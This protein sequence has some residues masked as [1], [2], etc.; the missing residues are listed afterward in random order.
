MFIFD[1]GYRRYVQYMWAYTLIFLGITGI[2]YF[3]AKQD[4]YFN[5]FHFDFVI[6]IVIFL[7]IIVLS[8]RHIKKLN[9]EAKK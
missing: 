4:E 5:I 9:R 7:L 8:V 3:L 6:F 2:I 1:K